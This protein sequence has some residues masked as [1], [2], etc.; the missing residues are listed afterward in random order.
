MRS[1]CSKIG[2]QTIWVTLQISNQIFHYTR[3][4]TPK[5]VTSWRG[6]SPHHCACGQYSFFRRMIA[7]V[8]S[9]WQHCVRFSR[10]EIWTSDF[11]LQKRTRYRSFDPA[12]L[13][14]FYS[15]ENRKAA[16]PVVCPIVYQ[17][18]PPAWWWSPLCEW[19]RNGT[20]LSRVLWCSIFAALCFHPQ[21]RAKQLQP[22]RMQTAYNSYTTS[23]N[24]SSYRLSR[25]SFS[26]KSKVCV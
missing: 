14:V 4:I 2:A 18:W 26:H 20:F 5:R 10:P 11:Q 3:C 23:Q 24:F 7:A 13:P 9:R 12:K 8:A 15:K 21:E 19:C 16:I 1:G 22:I 25:Q 6:P 17:Q